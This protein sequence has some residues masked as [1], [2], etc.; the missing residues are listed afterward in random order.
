MRW[1]WMQ[2]PVAMCVGARSEHGARMIRL[3]RGG[4]GE[5]AWQAPE[6]RLGGRFVARVVGTAT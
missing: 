4:S 5:A 2:V 1:W 6:G 3:D